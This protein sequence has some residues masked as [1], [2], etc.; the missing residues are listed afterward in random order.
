[1]RKQLPVLP[2]IV[3]P[4][5]V[6]RQ[7]VPQ[8]W[9]TWNSNWSFQN[10]E[11]AKDYNPEFLPIVSLVGGDILYVSDVDAVAELASSPQ[12]FPKDLRLYGTSWI[13]VTLC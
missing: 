8:R 1:M 9:Q 6:S 7:F 11:I 12:R 13:A 5:D 10:R 3:N 2:L 4:H